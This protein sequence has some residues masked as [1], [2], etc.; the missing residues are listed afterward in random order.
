MDKIT[1][2]GHTTLSKRDEAAYEAL[3]VLSVL[4]RDGDIPVCLRE[5]VADVLRKAGDEIEPAKAMA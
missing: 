2:K 1:I 5:L 3:G 4:Y